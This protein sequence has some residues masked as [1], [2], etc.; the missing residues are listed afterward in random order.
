MVDRRDRAT[1]QPIINR[2]ILPG[3]E[4]H[5]DDWGGYRNLDQQPNVGVHRVVVHRRHFVHPVTG[6]HTQDIESAWNRLKSKVKRRRG[7]SRL[8]L[9]ALLDQHMWRDWRGLQNPFEHFIEVLISHN[10]NHPV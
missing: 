8:D 2:C 9:Q 3:S 7:A 4:V 1:L 6:V 5:S 10:P